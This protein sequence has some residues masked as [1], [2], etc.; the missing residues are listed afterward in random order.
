MIVVFFYCVI[1]LLR[2]EECRQYFGAWYPEEVDPVALMHKII[3][4]LFLN[5]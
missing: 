4:H 3:G 5:P 2:L 1:V